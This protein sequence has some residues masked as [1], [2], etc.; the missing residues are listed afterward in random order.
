M[1]WNKQYNKIDLLHLF[2][3]PQLSGGCQH[4]YS[5]ITR[6]AGR[7]NEQSMHVPLVLLVL[8]VATTKIHF[9]AQALV[10]GTKQSQQANKAVMP[11]YFVLC[12]LLAIAL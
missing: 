7:A 8:I 11:A 2:V 1:L 9:K 6:Q 5:I 12:M 4:N 3:V 10:V